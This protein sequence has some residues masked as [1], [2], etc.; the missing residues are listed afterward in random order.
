MITLR[1]LHAENFKGLRSVDL[2]FPEQG[3]IL[4]EGHNEAGKSTLFEAVYVA[5]YGQPLV[6]EEENRPRQEEVI[7]HGQPR[8][9]VE[10]TF[11]VGPLELTVVRAFKRGAQQTQSAQLTIRRPGA[12]P[13]TVSRPTAVN[14]RILEEL[15]HLDGD[16]L[17]N[18]CFVEQKEL[19]R[20][21]EMD[22]AK[23]E[24]AIQKLLGL[25]QLTRLADQFRFR[26]EQQQ[27]LE[28]AN[29]L[30]A[31]AGAQA[32][33]RHAAA[34][35][36][37]LEERL[38]ATEMA[39]Y[40]AD[41]DRFKG[42]RAEAERRGVECEGRERN[43]REVLDRCER[44]RDHLEACDR[45][46]RQ[47]D[48]AGMQRQAVDRLAQQVGEL[49]DIGRE[50]RPAAAA[51]LAEVEGALAA[52][53]ALERE[54][55]SLAGAQAAVEAAERVVADL[56]RA[57]GLVEE[58]SQALR[59]ACDRAEEHA[60][61]AD[62]GRVRIAAQLDELAA[63]HGRLL[64]ALERVTA[65]EQE[66]QQLDALERQVMEAQARAGRLAELRETLGQR[67]EAAR[68]AA[69]AADEAERQ[70][71]MAEATKL[72]AEGR[73]ALQEWI[74][75]KEVE[76]SLAGYQR[77]RAA[78]DDEH[79]SAEADHAASQVRARGPRG[80]AFAA[81]IAAVVA[82]GAGVV[83]TPAFAVGALLAL[84]AGAAWV[85]YARARADARGV[86]SR[87]A[88]VEG[89][90]RELTMRHDAAVRAGGNPALLGQRERELQAARF[91]VPGTLDEARAALKQLG[92]E[93]D[94]P[95]RATQGAQAAVVAATGAAARLA[96]E[97]ERASQEAALAR[98]VLGTLE[99]EGDDPDRLLRDL[100]ARVDEQRS[101]ADAAGSAAQATAGSDVAWPADLARVE[102]AIA[103]CE[104]ARRAAEQ[105]ATAHESAAANVGREDAGAIAQAEED[106]AAAERPAE[107]LR[108]D[109]PATALRQALERRQRAEA[110]V[111]DA[112]ASV[113]ALVG[114]LGLPGERG[115]IEA[116]RGRLGGH[117]DAL[118]R[119]LAER[120]AL[121]ADMARERATLDDRLV[122]ARDAIRGVLDA[123]GP[124]VGPARLPK[125]GPVDG[126]DERRLGAELAEI[127]RALRAALDDLD[128]ATTKAALEGVLGE[129]GTLAQ[130]AREAEAN[131]AAAERAMRELLTARQLPTPE[132]YTTGQ[133]ARVWPLV[134]MVSASELDAAERELDLAHQRLY[135]ARDRVRRLGEDLQ[136]PET[137]L[138][139]DE[140]ERRVAELAEEREICQRAARLIQEA[141]DRVAR[142]V[143]P[144]TERNMQLLL[145]EL[146]ARRYWD[147]RLTPPEREDGELGQLDYRI[148]VWDPAAGRYVAK[149][150][151]SGGT[152]DQCSLALRLAFALATLPQELGVAPGFIF[153]DEP[154]SAFDAQ[155][156]RA[157]VDLLTTGT[158]AAQFPQV[159]VISH[160]H[161]FDPRAFQFHVRME[162]GRAVESDLPDGRTEAQ[163]RLAPARAVERV[164]SPA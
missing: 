104:A 55:T 80:L 81:S 27:E 12:E 5:L 74:R 50:A 40:L 46:G 84:G 20:L 162:G 87:V 41:R 64:L 94:D 154:L 160:H 96:A 83:W 95:A 57:E 127:V 11:T 93:V 146:T 158:I 145:P 109:E 23:R 86:A 77:E 14:K 108:A 58:R 164:A 31:L 67:E 33:E 153:L 161:A 103:A 19:G 56:R 159:V 118:D 34:E 30:R 60:R 78:L 53:A 85:A 137:P 91:A 9:T 156:A 123:A 115:A 35:A 147:V 45:V 21:E 113:A 149:N 119:R 152:R 61:E 140:C 133:L 54:R 132:A 117:I 51:R 16:N 157:L 121:E 138:A 76:G 73:A 114:P 4:I 128:E 92:S 18:S 141:R 36:V 42:A 111:R 151:F 39:A 59:R 75:L 90:R 143:L 66:R 7:Q 71:Q 136:H 131:V 100:G 47:L 163:G 3:S 89:R 25:E 68:K 26:R 17:R 155:R 102:A 106:L 99:Q 15:G 139:L 52:V 120:P 129:K 107:A 126:R 82:V 1:H 48:Q 88:A 2:T 24:Q 28:R 43:L 105:T 112:E 69:A 49:D 6:G 22:S 134:A 8:A 130:R 70:R 110:T 142:H 37:R 122:A 97:A 124:L 125:A 29:G 65:W 135:A 62:T 144:T 148:R 150:L 32:D 72:Q 79:R 116:E 13:E 101:A 44:V 98:S 63:R 38:D 10:L